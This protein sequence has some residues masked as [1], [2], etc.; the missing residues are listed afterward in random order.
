MVELQDHNST[1]KPNWCPGCGNFTILKSVQKALTELH[2]E[3][4]NAVLVSGVGCFA[5]L[6]YWTKTNGF[7]GLHG[8]SLPV[9]Q[10]IKLAN[11]DLTVIAFGGDGDGYSEGGNHFIHACRRDVPITYIVHNNGVFG[12]TTGQYSPTS[13]IGKKS[14]SSPLGSTERPLNPL[15]VAIASGATF[16]ARTYAGNMS[17]C[18]DILTK[19]IQHDGF[20]LVDVIQPCLTFGKTTKYYTE[21]V[22]YLDD[23]YDPSDKSIA[24]IKAVES[25]H[26]QKIACGILYRETKV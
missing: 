7:V 2:C 3:P 18:V 1:E 13:D 16:V 24:F 14:K 4:H 20:A 6:P 23:K 25:E 9:A 19:A 10:G 17:H 12:L 5:K 26:G 8:R 15:A 21:R 11:K 22:Y